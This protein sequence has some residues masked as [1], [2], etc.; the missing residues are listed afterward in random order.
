MKPRHLDATE[1]EERLIALTRQ[2]WQG[3]ITEGVLLR[4]LRR[5]VLRLSQD[6]YA[7]LVGVSRRTLS[8]MERDKGNVSIEVMNRAFRPLGLRVGLVPR[9][10]ELLKRVSPAG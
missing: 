4:T 3:E 7:G 1:R 6:E 9:Q 8:D 10:P 2:L 5:E